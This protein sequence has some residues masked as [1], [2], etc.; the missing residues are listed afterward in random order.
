MT[1]LTPSV[2]ISSLT[3][4]PASRS[5]GEASLSPIFSA[6]SGERR[7]FLR[8]GVE[9]TDA[10]VEILQKLTDRLALHGHHF[11]NQ[12]AGEHAIFIGNMTA[13]AQ[14]GAL[15]ATDD[16]LV[17]T[18]EFTDIFETDRCLTHFIAMMSGHGVD[19]VRGGNGACGIS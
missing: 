15:F 10:A 8:A 1:I 9:F 12:Q 7:R 11:G 3:A 4:W 13:Q 2:V 17:V 6:S 18:D 16:D 5:G 14:A 19:K